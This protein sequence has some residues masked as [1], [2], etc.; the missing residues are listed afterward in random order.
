MQRVFKLGLASAALAL[1]ATPAAAAVVFGGTNGSNLTAQATFDIVAGHLV[2]TLTN[3]SLVDVNDNP[4]MLHALFFDI[5]NNPG[6]TYTSA[7]I[8]STCTFVG[9]TLGTGT[10]VGAEFAFLQNANGLGSGITQDYGVSSA[11]YGIFGPGN[12]LPGAPDRGGANQPPDGPDFGILSAGY[13]A[14][15]DSNGMNQNQPFIK[16]SV[17][18][19]LGSFNGGLGSISNVRF[20]Y[21]TALTGEHFNGNTPPVPEPATWAMMLLGFGGIGVSMRRRR[22]QTASLR[23][24]A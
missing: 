7:N 13:I 12:V 10:N 5:A 15:N 4:N 11:G 21:D 9:T 2:L 20:Q 16:N 17:I 19:D 24:I 23:Q 8:C 18:F 14:G 6:L 22:K 3:T 1:T